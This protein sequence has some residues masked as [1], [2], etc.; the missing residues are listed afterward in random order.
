MG[1]VKLKDVIVESSEDIKKVL[2]EIS[3]V[4]NQSTGIQLGE[5]QVSMVENRLKSHMIKLGIP[6]FSDYL[7]YFNA[8][9]IAE[10]EKLVSLMTTHHT[11]F[12]REFNHF[13]YLESHLPEIVDR[14][15]ARGEKV[16]NIWSA[17]C[18]RGQ[19]VYSLSMFLNIYLKQVAPD[20][21]YQIFGTD[22]D[23]ESVKFASNGVYPWDEVKKIPMQYLGSNWV[24][25]T[26]QI[27][28]FAKIKD[29]L[30][31]PCSFG[32][33]NLNDIKLPQNRKFDIIFCRNVF[34]YFNMDQIKNIT[35][36][37][38][39][40][41]HPEGMFFI[42]ISESLNGIVENVNYVG[43]SVYSHMAKTKTNSA[44]SAP[45]I[46]A[47]AAPIVKPLTPIFQMPAMLKV[48]CVDDSQTILTLLK[49]ILTKD[50]GFEVVGTA[51]NGKEAIQK[52]KDLKPDLVTLDIHM[53]EM[54]GISYLKSQ[55]NDSHPPV[56]MI[57]SIN[58]E[59]SDTAMKSIELGASDYIE[60]PTMANLEERSDEIR[61]KL[62]L[63]FQF[64]HK[65]KKV[66]EIDN[67]FRKK[68][69]IKNTAEKLRIVFANL[70]AP[71]TKMTFDFLK[72][73][74]AQDPA[75]I[76]VYDGVYEALNPLFEKFKTKTTISTQLL[77]EINQIEDK[78][79]YF[80]DLDTNFKKWAQLIKGKKVSVAVMGMPSKKILSS[81]QEIHPLHLTLEEHGSGVNNKFYAELKE[82][83]Q[84]VVPLN[85]YLSV[86]E[87]FFVKSDD[88]K[89]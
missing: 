6:S 35:K 65:N 68:Y 22:I 17:A 71:S 16:I 43:P 4:V 54:D 29:D 13:E 87:D 15:R 27:A 84:A 50:F 37:L 59:N 60:K 88:M 58:R 78:K 32:V 63:S 64:K 53:P 14:A 51:L 72:A 46:V 44:V 10:T 55:M 11:Y 34:I 41:L 26:G 57:S 24:R 80:T 76:F 5:K 38:M 19:E 47:P 89:S 9:K 75:T 8:H 61:S 56:I 28:H 81:I 86:S 12:F 40:Y 42:G 31:K 79:I 77:P 62:K 3:K 52:V 69:E 23:P 20:F 25:G 21:N 74:H 49:K 18:S 1:Q 45:S 83:A 30:K 39:S 2:V 70:S 33:E 48:L 67:S 66:S 85:S 82:V 36:K 7:T 73:L